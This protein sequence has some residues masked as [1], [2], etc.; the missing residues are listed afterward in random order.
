MILSNDSDPDG[1]VNQAS[2]DLNPTDPGRQNTLNVPGE[3]DY[4]VDNSG[5]VT[6]TPA[7][8]FTGTSQI[9]YIVRDNTGTASNVATITV[10]VGPLALNDVDVTPAGVAVTRDVLFNDVDANGVDPLTLDLD[11]STPTVR[12]L[13]VVV[14]GQGT[15]AADNA[16]NITFTPAAG[17]TG[18]SQLPYAV[19]DVAGA[20]SSAG[21]TYTVHV[22]PITTD[23]TGTSL[24][25]QAV[26]INTFGNDTD[27]DGFDPSTLDL[28]PS[29]A[30]IDASV[31]VAGVGTF[32]ALPNGQVT[33]T[34][35]PAYAGGT[36]QVPYVVQDVFGAPSNQST[37]TITVGPY[38][39]L[40][41]TMFG[42]TYAPG[43]A[44]VTYTVQTV[45]RG[46]SAAPNVVVQVQLR[47]GLR[48]VNGTPFGLA[49]ATYDPDTGLLTFAAVPSLAA[50]DT[51][52]TTFSFRMP[53][54][55][56]AF[57]TGASVALPLGLG[58]VSD[59]AVDNNDGSL[60][61]ATV[62]TVGPLPVTLTRFTATGR[63][64]DAVLAWATA[65]EKDAAYFAV[66][67]SLDG[68]RTFAQIGRREAAGTT[69]VPQQYTL[70]DAGVGRTARTVYYRLRQV[71]FDGTTAF[72]NV[73]SVTFTGKQLANV[74]RLFPNPATTSTTLD[75]TEVEAG[76]YA[77][78]LY[79]ATGRLVQTATQLG[80]TQQPLDLTALP[81][82]S[83]V[84]R[85]TS[86]ATGFVATQRVVKE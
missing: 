25:G 45:N 66:E 53:D 36:V 12:D 10:T 17:F 39:D 22:G 55:G 76:T 58:G 75:L 47:A 74:V 59:P 38:A 20:P 49:G 43:R 41:T 24:N 4:A 2:V 5:V 11:P 84:V 30:D 64:A 85:V 44:P 42:D 6:F 72:S 29:D 61:P 68:G 16:G 34:P 40:V 54:D 52:S 71:D 86:A 14:N 26:T 70:T 13:T 33:F 1:T 9:S 21:A 51:I 27:L 7:A 18:T 62:T 56:Y 46:P 80:G 78:H 28:D 57:G 32:Q 77:V 15:F 73:E 50:G 83:Y 31:L 37:I 79:D 82:G 63:G 19:Q 65:S 8:G 67:R 81:T 60:P 69:T 3:G 35:D 23:D 48:N